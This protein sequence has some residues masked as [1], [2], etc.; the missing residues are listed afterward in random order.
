[1]EHPVSVFT[2]ESVIFQLPLLLEP[3]QDLAWHSLYTLG[4]RTVPEPFI[5]AIWTR[6][7]QF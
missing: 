4:I 7:E 1:M 3:M 5:E 6:T 2:E